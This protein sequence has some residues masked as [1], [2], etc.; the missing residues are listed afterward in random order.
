MNDLDTTNAD[1]IQSDQ[2]AA[3]N[4]Q[5]LSHQFNRF[6][7]RAENAE[8]DISAL[9]RIIWRRKL[10]LFSTFLNREIL[11]LRYDKQPLKEDRMSSEKILCNIL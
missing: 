5:K 1:Q 9:I 11:S 7:G 6:V 10:V 3:N 2:E 4:P 8:I